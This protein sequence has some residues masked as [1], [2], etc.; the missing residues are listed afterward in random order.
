MKLL[1][2]PQEFAA[3]VS[4]TM[5]GQLVP[6]LKNLTK[7]LQSPPVVKVEPSKGLDSVNVQRGRG[8]V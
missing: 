5:L 6:S 4:L 8:S 3:Q 7:A 2:K 1:E